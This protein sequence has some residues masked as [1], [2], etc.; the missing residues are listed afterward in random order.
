M[1]ICA[2]CFTLAAM[3][4]TNVQGVV[5]DETGATLPGASVSITGKKWLGTV[6]NMDG[7]FS[8]DVPKGETDIT[9]R[10]VGYEDITVKV[11]SGLMRIDMV[12]ANKTLNEVVS[13]GYGTIKRANVTGSVGKV[14]GEIFEGMPNTNP[15]ELLQGQISGVEVTTQSGELGGNVQIRVR[16]TASINADPTPLYVIDGVVQEE[17]DDENPMGISNIDPASIESIEVLKD[18]A[19]AA[20]YGSRA[21]NGVILITTKLPKQAQPTKVTGSSSFS[22]ATLERKANAM[23]AEEWINAVSNE[24]DR[25]YVTQYGGSGATA[26]DD[27][28]TRMAMRGGLFDAQYMKDPRWANGGKG[29]PGAIYT[30]A[31]GTYNFEGD[32]RYVDWQD[33]IY[34]L[35]PTQSYNLNIS[36]ANDLTKF[37]TSASFTDQDGL[38]RNSA[39]KRFN[40]NSRFETKFL[41]KFTFGTNLSLSASWLTGAGAQSGKNTVSNTVIQ[42][43]PVVDAS[44][45]DLYQGAYPYPSYYWA[46]SSISPLA[47]LEQSERQRNSFGSKVTA[48]LRYD[49]MEGLTAEATGNYSMGNMTLR[50]FI[51]GTIKGQ[52]SSKGTNEQTSS[53]DRRTN[54]NTY[55]MQGTLNYKKVLAEKH[56]LNLMAGMSYEYRGS[57]CVYISATGFSSSSVPSYTSSNVTTASSKYS[58]STPA[59]LVSYFTRW[60]YGYDN[61]YLLNYSMRLD[62]SSRFAPGNR[63]SFFPAVGGAWRIDQEEFWEP[64]ANVM[65]QMK[66]RVSWGQNGNNRVANTASKAI[67]S[68]ADYSFGDVT[69]GGFI[70]GQPENPTLTWEKTSS[71]NFALDMGWFKNRLQLTLEYYNK[72]TK[73]LLY[74][75]N[76]PAIT[77]FTSAYA[78]IGTIV[79]QGL[80]FDFRATPVRTRNFTWNTSFNA[81]HN[82]NE[83]VD[84]GGND[85]VAVGRR[86]N[87]SQML[88]IGHGLREYYMYEAVGV[89]QTEED[90]RKYP[91]M[92][93]SVV[94]DVR[95]KDQNGDGFIDENDMTFVG[96]PMPDWTYGWTNR[97]KYKNWDL[98]ITMTAQTGGHIYSCLQEQ[99]EKTASLKIYQNNNYKWWANPWVSTELVGN[100]TTPSTEST[101]GSMVSTRHLYST[102]FF[103]IKSILLGYNFR[104]PK[105][106]ACSALRVYFSMQNVAM[107]DNYEAGFSPESNNATW[108]ELADYDFGSHPLARRFTIGCNISF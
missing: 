56:D 29:I 62:G 21:A 83:V 47:T 53:F 13:I 96:T 41:K 78:N 101:T 64:M 94:G 79:N 67:L 12:P 7:K 70:M 91:C 4:Q 48:F 35:A 61:R 98:S 11:K 75:R 31:R 93:G 46:G 19:S 71:W 28:D 38:L 23:S 25:N 36:G 60:Q 52:W 3:A 10:F 16:G 103:K 69:A 6:T 33:E 63:Y 84:L 81:G 99:L 85:M 65:N 40:V 22:L 102:D 51:P 9:I 5:Y 26:D 105:E 97:L 74:Q 106:S 30:D 1:I 50:S 72:T 32:L 43:V 95:F 76:I 39:D 100:G 14:E 54:S 17:I 42:M 45:G 73:D 58:A 80:E 34:Q 89:Y 49:I 108:K 88:A 24:I 87:G 59:K 27:F 68:A 57:D 37:Y 66:F 107:W 44:M 2:L 15:A 82:I 86:N 18:A 92:K 8:I 77:G 104:M 90:L 20:I 55:L